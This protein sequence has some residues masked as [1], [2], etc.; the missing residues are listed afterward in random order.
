[1]AP[2]PLPAEMYLFARALAGARGD[3][4]AAALWCEGA[5]PHS[6]ATQIL[7]A[8]ISIGSTTDPAWAGDAT[9]YAAAQMAFFETL[10]SGSV[11]ARL[12]SDRAIRPAPVGFNLISVTTAASGTLVGQGLPKPV[13]KFEIARDTA[14][15]SKVVVALIAS[16]ELYRS[17]GLEGLINAELKGAVQ[18]ALDREFIA[19]TT[20]GL[21]SIPAGGADAIAVYA[22]MGKALEAVAPVGTSRLYWLLSP[23]L[24]GRLS[25]TTDSAGAAAFP[26]LSA[27]GGELCNLPTLVS[28]GVAETDLV[29]VD[30]QSLAG[31]LTTVVFEASAEAALELDTAPVGGADAVITPLWQVGATAL[32]AEIS[33]SL[34]SIRPHGAARIT[35]I[36]AA[37]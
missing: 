35:G 22:A 3:I 29:L 20:Q 2:V 5:Y 13:G 1:M 34:T 26:A 17:P 33:Y 14:E 32:R 4:M 23:K 6:K 12:W 31:D 27:L 25:T 28:D 37:P 8:A 15:P 11:F 10:R 19:V 36:E 21:P 30:A 9:G 24:A 7:K 18:T 16:T